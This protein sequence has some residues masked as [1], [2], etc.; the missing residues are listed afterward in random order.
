MEFMTTLFLLVIWGVWLDRNNIIFNEKV[1][2]PS[3]TASLVCGIIHAF[4][5]H[6]KVS[7]QRQVLELDIDRSA[8]WVFFYGASQNNLCEG[9][10]YSS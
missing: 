8:P 7:K 9:A 3:I 4:P 6:I 10:R 2:T 5:P 1:S